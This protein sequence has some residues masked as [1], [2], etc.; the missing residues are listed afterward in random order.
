MNK[1]V[2]QRIDRIVRKYK[3]N[4]N[5]LGIFLAGAYARGEEHEYSDI[6][7]YIVTKKP[8]EEYS[9]PIIPMHKAFIT[10][11][12]L[13]HCFREM[14]WIYSRSLLLNGK[15]LFDPE[16]ILKKLKNT[17]KKY[18]ED[19]RQFELRSNPLH[20]LTQLSRAKWALKKNDLAT[21]VYLLEKTGF[22]IIYFYY[23]LNKMYL[24]SERRFMSD[25]IKKIYQ[26][27]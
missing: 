4:K 14:D 16:S 7:L 19:I 11:K 23:V 5:V 20:A 24:A 2:K 15:I 1:K 12:N 3:K 25:N 17:I 6:D 27:G 9:D 26:A 21:C 18:P 8:V 13:K 10:L 22:E